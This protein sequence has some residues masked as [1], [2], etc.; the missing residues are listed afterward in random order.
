VFWYVWRS[1]WLQNL[2]ALESLRSRKPV[3]IVNLRRSIYLLAH[4]QVLLLFLRKY[5]QI[6][7]AWIEEEH[8]P[9]LHV[10]ICRVGGWRTNLYRGW[11]L[12]PVGED[13][14]VH[15]TDN[16]TSR[17]LGR[18]TRHT[19]LCVSCAISSW[20]SGHVTP[21]FAWDML[22]IEKWTAFTKYSC[23]IPP[24]ANLFRFYLSLH[25]G[26]LLFVADY[27]SRDLLDS[28]PIC[29]CERYVLSFK[30]YYFK[31]GTP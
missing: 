20:C 4:S 27:L 6:V 31:I 22:S 19:Y 12:Q 9:L 14:H 24:S 28:D 5:E 10:R 21:P 8:W 15:E 1:R 16:T 11:R 13:C 26:L 29:M 3:D 25:C 2:S 17:Y 23:Q 18:G 30:Y 7:V